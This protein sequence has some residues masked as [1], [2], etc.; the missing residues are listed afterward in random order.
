MH[1]KLCI[2]MISENVTG[3]TTLNNT[4]KN[5]FKSYHTCLQLK[6]ENEKRASYLV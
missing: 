2:T 6:E 3:G 5:Y 1:L 4:E